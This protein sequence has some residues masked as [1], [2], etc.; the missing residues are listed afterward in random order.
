MSAAVRRASLAGGALAL[1][2]LPFLFGVRP[3]DGPFAAG[4]LAAAALAAPGAAGMLLGRG[5]GAPRRFVQALAG[6]A[7]ANVA[8]AVALRVI[9]VPPGPASFAAALCVF[10]VGAGAVGAARGGALPDPRRNVAALAI[11]LA[12]FALAAV[13][14][15]A[16]VP[17]LE[18]QDSEVQGTAYGLAHDLVPLCLTNRSTLYFFAHPT[19]LHA[20]NAATLT[21]AGELETVRPPYDAARRARA[22][23]ATPAGSRVHR[24]WQAWRGDVER[25]DHSLSWQRNVYGPFRRDPALT[26][27]RAPNFALAAAVAVLLFAAARRLGAGGIDAALLVASY[28]TLPE[29][30]VRSGYGG[31][32]AL[33]AA[34][35]LA[36]AKL[37][38][39]AA[40]GGRSAYAAGALA[41]LA[42]QKAVLVA[43]AAVVTH[44]VRAVN[45][46]MPRAALSAVP[47]VAGIV[48]GGAAFWIYGITVAPEEFV[49][50]HL[51]AHGFQRFAGGEALGRGGEPMYASRAGIW[52]E[53]ARHFGWAWCAAAA[54]GVAAAGRAVLGS[55]DSERGRELLL[56]LAWAA[57]GALLFTATDWRQTKH[58][59]LI[60]PALVALMTPALR[61]PAPL[62][63]AMR[64]ALVFSIAWN[65]VWIARLAHD[66]RA[67]TVT[68]VW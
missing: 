55:V 57:I 42:N 12:A 13:A 6:A 62:R 33:T 66:F 47:Y 11:A 8:A 18:D 45:V 60:V 65:A 29:I 27:T 38:T 40:G 50:D 10:T 61:G 26:G 64:G 51:L 4:L 23:Q 9:G 19:L 15:T 59:C 54:I 5:R 21:L 20:L 39:S 31:Y 25:T 53:F 22:K 14:G 16:V 68:P 37:A 35:F 52:L 63:W 34:I 49:A 3:H 24:A 1:P 30:F 32:Y 44:A 43:A 36:S 28:A 58:L 2:I 7:V 46:R 56:L 17:P 67:L 41:I 48:A